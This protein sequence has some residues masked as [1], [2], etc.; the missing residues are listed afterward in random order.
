MRRSCS[1]GKIQIEFKHSSELIVGIIVIIITIAITKSSRID[2]DERT[3]GEQALA[4]L[5]AIG[6]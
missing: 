4:W 2:L 6:S 3:G 1:G 5:V